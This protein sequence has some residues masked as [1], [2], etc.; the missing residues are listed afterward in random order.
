M[1]KGFKDF[2]LRGNVIDMA[3]GVVIGASFGSVV[4]SL[5]KGILTPFIAAIAK[6]PDFSD[7][8]FTLNGSVFN[9]GEF[10]NAL[11]SFL[12]VATAIYFFVVLPINKLM[13]RFNKPAPTEAPKM[14]N[15]PECLSLI[16][17]AAKRC[18]HCC[19]SL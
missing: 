8:S 10:F 13:S 4:T 14:K 2:V 18:S 9:Y 19:V 3:V 1:L 11:I 7:L 5:V 16:P 15:C 12:L 17:E 6:V